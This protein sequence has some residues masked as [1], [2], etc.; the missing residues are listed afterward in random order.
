MEV[1]GGGVITSLT[2]SAVQMQ[3]KANT[4]V[5]LTT[6]RLLT[7][8]LIVLV[9]ADTRALLHCNSCWHCNSLCSEIIHDKAILRGKQQSNY[10]WQKLFFLL[11][12]K[13]KTL[14]CHQPWLQ[15]CMWQLEEFG[16]IQR[17]RAL[18]FGAQRLGFESTQ[19][20]YFSRLS[21]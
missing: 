16:M 17:V 18:K 10:D 5:V 12:N 1:V 9:F 3:W 14:C 4:V 8:R 15:Q 21:C 11:V 6:I 13:S 2:A 19:S 20:Q 7:C